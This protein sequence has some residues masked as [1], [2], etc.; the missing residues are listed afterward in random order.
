[1]QKIK[2]DLLK[3]AEEI[4]AHNLS[5]LPQERLGSQWERSDSADNGHKE[6]AGT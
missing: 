2:H 3:G 4:E 5:L 6:I 1:M